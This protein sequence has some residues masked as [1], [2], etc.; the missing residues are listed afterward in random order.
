MKR[1]F[2]QFFKL[3]IAPV[4]TKPTAKTLMNWNAFG[5]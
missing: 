2:I 5:Q 3:R 4:E 1:Q